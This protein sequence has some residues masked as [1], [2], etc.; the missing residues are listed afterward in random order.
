MNSGNDIQELHCEVLRFFAVKCLASTLFILVNL[1]KMMAQ[2]NLL[3]M[4]LHFAVGV[5]PGEEIKFVVVAKQFVTALRN[6]RLLIGNQVIRRIVSQ[7]FH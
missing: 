2:I 4:E 3:E 7:R 6:T 5:V 1:Q